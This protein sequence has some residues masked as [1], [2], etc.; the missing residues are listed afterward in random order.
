M[1]FWLQL[2]Q[3][4]HF[5][6]LYWQKAI[7]K[8]LKQSDYTKL[9]KEVMPLRNRLKEIL[10][11]FMSSSRAIT[12]E[13]LAAEFHRSERTIRNDI[14]EINHFLEERQYSPI[15]NIRLYGY[16]AS[17]SESERRAISAH[18]NEKENVEFYDPDER[19]TLLLLNALDSAQHFKLY[20]MEER[21]LTSKSTLDE[22][23]RKLRFYLRKYNLEI[24]STTKTGTVLLGNELDIRA[25]TYDFINKMTMREVSL[26]EVT[27][28]IPSALLAYLDQKVI[29]KVEA[30]YRKQFGDSPQLN[31]LYKKQIILLITIWVRR[32]QNGHVLQAD[33]RYEQKQ[34]RN[35]VEAFV[36]QICWQFDLQVGESETKYIIAKITSLYPQN[37]NIMEFATA[38][39]LTLQMI[40]YVEEKLG[41]SF[42]SVGGELYKGIYQHMGGLLSRLENGVQLHNPLKENIQTLYAATYKAVEQFAQSKL[43]AVLHKEVSPDEIAF[44]TIYFSTAEFKINQERQQSY[45]AVVICNHGTAT[46]QLLAEFLRNNFPVDIIAILGTDDSKVLERMDADLVFS[47]VSFDYHQKPVLHLNPIVKEQDKPLIEAFLEAHQDK[48]RFYSKQVLATNLF[49]DLLEWMKASEIEW[50][51]ADFRRIE[52]IFKKNNLVINKREVQPMLEDVLKSTDVRIQESSENWQQA[53]EKAAEPLLEEGKIETRYIKAMIDSVEEYGPYIVIGKHLA[54]A[55]A[56]PEDGVNELGVSVMTLKEPVMFG[57]EWNDPVKII[58]CLAASDAYS[59]LNIMKS[60]VTLIQNE[61]KIVEL[62]AADTAENF[63]QQLLETE[64]EK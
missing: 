50:K 28:Q 53:I 47:T 11:K 49:V 19:F 30:I 58:F 4:L 25:M 44:L 24:V 31:A 7:L 6:L 14:S 38:Q 36:N 5:C 60:I 23:M 26:I 42:A 33:I 2:K 54:L 43:Q 35:V 48:A 21:L 56:R 37:S 55:H 59:H 16:K 17:F 32:I 61:A 41:I 64:E 34:E 15:E 18:I 10:R 52:Q 12:L 63:I 40:S 8:N 39:V 57:H 45:K 22:D 3:R 51:E 1:F 46:G 9:K 29:Q 62:A 20:E 13:E 27:G